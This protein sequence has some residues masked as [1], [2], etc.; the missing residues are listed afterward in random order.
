MPL[1][2]QRGSVDSRLVVVANAPGSLACE[3]RQRV[4]KPT[5]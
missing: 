1:T 4:V 2:A 5:G 3:D